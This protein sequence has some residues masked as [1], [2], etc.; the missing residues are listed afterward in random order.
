M[1]Q[2]KALVVG[3]SNY[4]PPIPSLKG[5][6]NDAKAMADLLGSPQGQFR[7][8]EIITL[9]D[10]QAT[11]AAIRE[12]LDAALSKAGRDDTVF[13]YMAGHG[14]VENGAYYFVAHDTTVG[15]MARTGVPLAELRDK[16]DASPSRRVFVWLDFC[17]SGGVAERSL[18]TSLADDRDIIERTLRVARGAGKVIVAACTK[19]QKSKETDYP[20]GR[21]GTFTLALLEGLRGRATNADGEVTASTLYEYVAKRV[22][23]EWHD[24][25]PVMV[26]HME[27]V[28]VLMHYADRT[29]G[30][31]GPTPVPKP[32]DTTVCESSGAWVLVG[33][34]FLPSESVG[35]QGERILIEVRPRSTQEHADIQRLRPGHGRGDTIP[36]A[37]GDDALVARVADI[38]S[39]SVAG[40]QVVTITLTPE[41]VQFGGG[42]MESSINGISADEIAERRAGRLLLNNPPAPPK[43]RGY[44]PED[45]VEGYIRG[46]SSTR[47]PAERAVLQEVYTM[48]K[49][50]SDLLLALARLKLLYAMK[51][52]DCVEQILELR[53]GPVTDGK[54]HVRFRGQR[55]RR[56]S[57]VEP[58]VIAV[59][60]DCPLE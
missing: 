50:G 11:A 1:G 40:R 21:H 10:A 34:L 19:D 7:G 4:L 6:A 12:Q 47:Y 39:Q 32:A 51:A 22:E 58:H 14:H 43:S 23:S 49:G 18:D 37:H 20:A 38:T 3:V 59:E 36:F 44:K 17:H 26:S 48:L 25:R 41:K 24:Q 15:Q 31:S 2:Q 33:D 52:S 55:A 46:G 8:G 42:G 16:F 45:F 60:G 13:V 56:Y 54:C 29:G 53:L 9:L 30:S 28:I 5:V 35:Q 27:G 57:N